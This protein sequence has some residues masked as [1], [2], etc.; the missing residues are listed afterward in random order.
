V[1]RRLITS[2]DRRE[3]ARLGKDPLLLQLSPVELP[4]GQHL[5][6]RNDRGGFSSSPLLIAASASSAPVPTWLKCGETEPVF[7]RK[8]CPIKVK[9]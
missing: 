1:V 2:A 4:Q 6:Y 7:P 3:Q 8:S 5:A 9:Y